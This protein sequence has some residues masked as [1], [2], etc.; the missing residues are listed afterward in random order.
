MANYRV[1]EN[2]AL[3]QCILEDLRAN[4]VNCHLVQFLDLPKYFL[5]FP[6]NTVEIYDRTKLNECYNR[7]WALKHHII[8]YIDSAQFLNK[9][10]FNRQ[11]PSCY[12]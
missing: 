9:F 11:I 1:K 7:L 10:M 2:M 4:G 8:R 6:N 3:I 5:V 12:E